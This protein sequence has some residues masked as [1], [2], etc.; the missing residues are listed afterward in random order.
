MLIFKNV[1]RNIGSYAF[2]SNLG[3][4]QQEIHFYSSRISN[5]ILYETFHALWDMLFDMIF[6]MTKKIKK[7]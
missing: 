1:V 5:S 6:Q 2:I 4:A 7:E 3:I